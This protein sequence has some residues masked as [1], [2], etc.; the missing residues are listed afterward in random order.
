MKRGNAKRFLRAAVLLAVAVK[1][2]RAYAG[3]EI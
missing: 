2:Y 1:E 3:K